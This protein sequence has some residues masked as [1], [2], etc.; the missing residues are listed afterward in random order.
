MP[1]QI[2]MGIDLASWLERYYQGQISRR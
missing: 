1:G 2:F